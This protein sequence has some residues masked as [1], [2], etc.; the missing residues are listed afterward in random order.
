M[1]VRDKGTGTEDNNIC[2]SN[3]PGTMRIWGVEL[4]SALGPAAA[5]QL[6]EQLALYHFSERLS[7]HQRL[8]TCLLYP[9]PGSQQDRSGRLAAG[10]LPLA[11]AGRGFQEEPG[12]HSP[13]I[14][15]FPL[16]ARTEVGM[17]ALPPS[18][19]ERARGEEATHWLLIPLWLLAL[20]LGRRCL[21]RDLENKGFNLVARACFLIWKMGTVIT[22]A[23]NCCKSQR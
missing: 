7:P 6:R 21:P 5:L 18:M 8:L 13:P 22:P 20:H 15:S 12:S 14:S 11:W 9:Y 19:V 16:E 2:F 3:K 23:W 4:A 17:L 1:P 10:C